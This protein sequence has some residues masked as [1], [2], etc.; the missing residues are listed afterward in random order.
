MSLPISLLVLLVSVRIGVAFLL[1]L[2]I[3]LEIP[4][5]TVPPPFVSVFCPGSPILPMDLADFR[6]SHCCHYHLL[7]L[8][9]HLTSTLN[10]R[11]LLCGYMQTPV[12]ILPTLLRLQL[13]SRTLW[14]RLLLPLPLPL[15][16]L[17]PMSNQLL[18]QLQRAPQLHH[19]PVDRLLRPLRHQHLPARVPVPVRV[20]A[21]HPASLQN[22]AN[23]LRLHHLI[24]QVEQQ[25]RAQLQP[26][27]H[28][29]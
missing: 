10:P 5:R 23:L 9:Y 20:Q 27:A 2:I 24:R 17:L 19:R 3:T 21:N 1:P 11:K 18:L 25:V 14:I 7:W 26:L 15:Q 29:P 12:P 8:K 22:K 6:L 4:T 13:F 28:P 16:L